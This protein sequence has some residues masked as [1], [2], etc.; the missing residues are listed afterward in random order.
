VKIS[1]RSINASGNETAEEGYGAVENE[2]TDISAFCARCS[3]RMMAISAP[4]LV[5]S[6]LLMGLV[7]GRKLR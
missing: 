4:V 6:V 3:F 5:F 7:V 2:S 1:H